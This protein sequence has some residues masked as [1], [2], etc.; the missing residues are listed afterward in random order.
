MREGAVYVYMVYVYI[1]VCV[2]ITP[3]EAPAQV[4]IIVPASDLYVRC[5]TDFPVR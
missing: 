5:Q 1:Y 2:Y 4:K 3:Q